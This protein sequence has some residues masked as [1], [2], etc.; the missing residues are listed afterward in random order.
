MTKLPTK[1]TMA[2]TAFLKLDSP[3][4]A[5]FFMGQK[6]SDGRKADAVYIES[7]SVFWEVI[8]NAP[9]RPLDRAYMKE[10]T[11]SR[12]ALLRNTELQDLRRHQTRGVSPRWPIQ[13]TARFPRS[14]VRR[15]GNLPDRRWIMRTLLAPG[16]RL[17][18]AAHQTQQRHR[19]RGQS[20]LDLLLRA[21][22]TRACRVRGS[23]PRPSHTENRAAAESP[24]SS[25]PSPRRPLCFFFYTHCG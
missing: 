2:R 15:I 25:C 4:T 16:I 10:A 24:D 3:A 13:N 1:R 19:Q 9:V 8:N 21:R 23:Q 18:S 20:R 5:L 11:A 6:L 14:H 17:S 22:P 7:R 12:T